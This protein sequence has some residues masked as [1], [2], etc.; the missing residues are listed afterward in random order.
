MHARGWAFRTSKM[1]TFRAKVGVLCQPMDAPR[2]PDVIVG[3]PVILL[4][5]F[6]FFVDIY[7]REYRKIYRIFRNA[8]PQKNARRAQLDAY[9]KQSERTV[10]KAFKKKTKEESIGLARVILRNGGLFG[11]IENG[12]TTRRKIQRSQ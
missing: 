5:V 8:V 7:N 12:I 9:M 1:Y 3:K 6:F 11:S 4:L 2:T 10:E